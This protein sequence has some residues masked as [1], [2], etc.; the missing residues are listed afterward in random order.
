[1]LGVPGMK[2]KSIFSILNVCALMHIAFFLIFNSES[3]NQSS[4]TKKCNNL[5]QKVKPSTLIASQ[6]KSLIFQDLAL[7]KSQLMGL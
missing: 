6:N 4:I 3:I 1:M 7:S 2:K 5:P